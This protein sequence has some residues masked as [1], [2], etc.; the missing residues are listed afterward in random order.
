MSL[1]RRF[2]VGNSSS[3]SLPGKAFAL[4]S[5]L[6]L[7]SKQELQFYNC[8]RSNEAHLHEIETL[9]YIPTTNGVVEMGSYENILQNWNLVNQA[10]SIFQTSSSESNSISKSDLLPTNPLDK[11]Q[12][13]D[14]HISFSDIGFISGTGEETQETQTKNKRQ[15]IQT[16][17]SVLEAV[18]AGVPMIAWPLYA[19]QHVNRN[20]MVAD[21]KVAVAVEQ[22]EGDMFVSGEEVE[23][24]VRELMESERG[25]DIRKTSLKFKDMAKDALGEFGSSTKALSNLVQTW[26]FPRNQRNNNFKETIRH[27]HKYKQEHVYKRRC[28]MVIRHVVDSKIFRRKQE[29]QFYNCER[30]N[31]AHLHEIETL[32]YIPTTN[33]VV[34]MG[35]YENILQNWN[36]VNQAKSIFQTSSSESNSISKSDLLPTN[37]LDKIQTF[38][39][40][41]SFSDIGFISGTGEETQETQTKNKRQY[42]QTW[43]SVLEAVVAGVPMIA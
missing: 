43:N 32:I 21:M 5:V 37:P 1:T 40:H 34:E 9:I 25:R 26:P 10:K 38:D 8:E 39:Q 27:R 15:Y 19:E 12:T 41:I 11:I 22:R 6:W 17:N 3:I 7:N 4:D 30:S 29:L 36:L 14:Q 28:G 20:L 2:S 23:K 24:R 35:S 33:G 31:E 16:W 13:F 42:I 18:V